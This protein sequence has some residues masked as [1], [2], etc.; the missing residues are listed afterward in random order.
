MGQYQSLA[1]SIGPTLTRIKE[2]ILRNWFIRN[3]IIASYALATY[4]SGF[5]SI[6]M[7]VTATFM[8]NFVGV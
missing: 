1:A 6:L 4:E 7:F 5:L 3:F 8:G 2:A